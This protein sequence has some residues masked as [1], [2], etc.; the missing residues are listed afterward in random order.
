VRSFCEGCSVERGL[1]AGDRRAA[2]QRQGSG[3]QKKE[4]SFPGFGCCF[5]K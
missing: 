5:R 3:K 2:G 4:R 1:R